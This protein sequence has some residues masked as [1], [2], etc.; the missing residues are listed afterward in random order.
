M[1]PDGISGAWGLSGRAIAALVFGAVAVSAAVFL[2]TFEIDREPRATSVAA[3]RTA[4]R[5]E[6]PVPPASPV[7]SRGADGGAAPERDVARARGEPPPGQA[8]ASA[9]PSKGSSNTAPGATDPQAHG[10]TRAVTGG[11]ASKPTS[12]RN[13]RASEPKTSV[14]AAQGTSDRTPPVLER[15]RF[16]PPA[17]EG[18]GVTMLTIQASD[19]LSGVKSV[20]GEIQSPSGLATLPIPLQDVGGDTFTV[21]IQIPR[22]AESGVWFVKWISLT[23]AA[24][25]ASLDQALSVETALPGGKLFVHSSESDSTA[26]EVI[27]VWFDKATVGEENRNVI[28]V[29]ATDEGSGIASMTGACQS[30]SKSALIWF[31]STLNPASGAW[32]GEVVLPTG[33]DCGHWGVQQLSVKD[34]AGNTTLLMGDAP[35]LAGVGFE[36]TARPDCDSSPPTLDALS[37]SP[38]IVSNDAASEIRVTAIVSDVGSGAATMTGW[39]E[40]PVSEGGQ[41]PKNHFS[42]SANPDDPKAPWTGV[43]EVP[44]FAAKGIWRVGVIRLEDKAGNVREYRSA[45]PVV[46]GRVFEVQ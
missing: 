31:H 43:V 30:A 41:V 34:K 10:L 4:V 29:E 13:G 2:A 38:T 45:D 28:K 44:Q 21:A 18:G 14:D 24:H 36:V 5:L 9:G 11:E 7:S 40:G 46:S 16:D 20:R 15:M 19:D 37:L 12:T 25:N 42:C 32:E 6:A 3:A 1:T 27:R 8:A 39:F 26:P 22:A 33:A 17:V 35:L 23:D